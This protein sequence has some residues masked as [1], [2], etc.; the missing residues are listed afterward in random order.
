LL[1]ELRRQRLAFAQSPS[2]GVE[3]VKE[4]S[5]L[6][7]DLAAV[8]LRDGIHVSRAN[9]LDVTRENGQRAGGSALRTGNLTGSDAARTLPSGNST[10]T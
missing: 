5:K 3:P 1:R 10:T 8:P 7:G 2:H 6:A 9:A 4:L